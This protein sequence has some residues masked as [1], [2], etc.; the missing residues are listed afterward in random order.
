MTRKTLIQ[1]QSAAFKHG[2][3]SSI[4]S[5]FSN[6]YNCQYRNYCNDYNNFKEAERLK[7]CSDIR[8][9]FL[10]NLKEYTKPETMVLKRLAEIKTELELRQLIDGKLQEGLSQDRMR[11]M[12]LEK[13]FLK[14]LLEYKDVQMKYT[15][16]SKSEITIREVF[17]DD[18]IFVVPS[19]KG[20]NGKSEGNQAKEL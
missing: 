1:R 19:K 20:E 7:G 3:R 8:N 5:K 17:G 16:G 9:A 4:L 13:D 18:E 11:L 15:V 6:C 2:D 14:L 12:Y 10:A